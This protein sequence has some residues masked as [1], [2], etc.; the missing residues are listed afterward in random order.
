MVKKIRC[1][2]KEEKYN[3]LCC[4]KTKEQILIGWTIWLINMDKN[5]KNISKK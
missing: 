1:N 2:L 5:R 3:K 4:I